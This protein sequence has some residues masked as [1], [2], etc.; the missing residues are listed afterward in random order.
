[1]VNLGFFDGEFPV[2]S[3]DVGGLGSDLYREVE[4]IGAP[5][6]YSAL[7]P[8]WLELAIAYIR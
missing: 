6:Q 5:L 1:V 2:I 3:L 7:L 8:L 4:L